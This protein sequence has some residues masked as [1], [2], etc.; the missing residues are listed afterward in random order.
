MVE[1]FCRCGMGV[2]RMVESAAFE[3]LYVPQRLPSE[4]EKAGLWGER[5]L[6]ARAVGVHPAPFR[7]R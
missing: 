4:K 1:G 6:V 3:G 7:T 5:V 2:L